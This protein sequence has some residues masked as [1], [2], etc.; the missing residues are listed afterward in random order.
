MANHALGAAYRNT[1]RLLAEDLLDGQALHAVVHFGASAMSVDISDVGAIE[2]AVLQS[3]FDASD[4]AAPVGMT[5]GDTK[6]IG[7]RSIAGH[8]GENLRA[9]TLGVFQLLDNEHGGPFA[10]NEAITVQ[11]EGPRRLL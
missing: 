2:S 9:A 6:S 1:V 5:V 10:E 4:G 3:A 11:I 7:C 8:L